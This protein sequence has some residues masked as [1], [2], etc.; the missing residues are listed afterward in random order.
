MI[1]F[2]I[3]N[4]LITQEELNEFEIEIELSLPRDYK[5]HM[6]RYNGGSPLSCYLYFGEPD[7]GI[8]LFGFKSIKYGTP[9]VEKQDYL[10][11]KHLSIGYTQTGYLSMSLDEKDYGSIFVYYSDE[12]PKEIAFSFTEFLEGLVDYTD[13]Y[14]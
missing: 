3:E 12:D 11:E 8:L 13:V 2:E 10:P 7:D 9:L 14:E 6:L 4:K 1:D 5:A